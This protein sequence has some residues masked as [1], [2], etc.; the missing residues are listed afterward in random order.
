MNCLMCL[1]MFEVFSL[2]IQEIKNFKFFHFCQLFYEKILSLSLFHH[3]TYYFTDFF[4]EKFKKY[5][6]IK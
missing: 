4:F 2:F 1:L 3:A 6:K 5:Q